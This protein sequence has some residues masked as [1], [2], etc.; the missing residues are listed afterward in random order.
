MSLRFSQLDGVPGDVL[1]D[2]L[3]ALVAAV[4]R[5]APADTLARTTV[6]TGH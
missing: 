1:G 5:A 4:H 3:Q 2:L 6:H